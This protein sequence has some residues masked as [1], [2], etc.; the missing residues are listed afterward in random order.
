MLF[1]E[2]TKTLTCVILGFF[3]FEFGYEEAVAVVNVGIE[4]L[5]LG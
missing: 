5:A 4:P 2:D 1:R 3:F